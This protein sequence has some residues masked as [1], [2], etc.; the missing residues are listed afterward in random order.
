[1][2]EKQHVYVKV[3]HQEQYDGDWPPGNL[4]EAMRWIQQKLHSI[5]IEHRAS[6]SLDIDS[7]S[8]YEDSHFA[9]ISIAYSRLETDGEY[10]DRL[11]AQR[12]KAEA[13]ANRERQL[14]KA[15]QRKYGDVS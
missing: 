7:V 9:R 12:F 5:P 6:A 8:G 14:Y 13:E 2:S 3:F 11:A 4:A 1:M 15:L 10:K